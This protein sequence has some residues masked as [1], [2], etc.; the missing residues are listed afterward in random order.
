MEHLTEIIPEIF[1][2]RNLDEREKNFFQQCQ[3]MPHNLQ[4]VSLVLKRFF[5]KRWLGM[6]R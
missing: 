3:A 1:D 4:N 2:D 5:R 6:G